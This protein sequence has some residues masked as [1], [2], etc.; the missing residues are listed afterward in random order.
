MEITCYVLFR[1]KMSRSFRVAFFLSVPV[2][3]EIFI[4]REGVVHV[5]L[6]LKRNQPGHEVKEKRERYYE[7]ERISECIFCDYEYLLSRR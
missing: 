4:I 2:G 7:K 5:M 3:D 6:F 1:R